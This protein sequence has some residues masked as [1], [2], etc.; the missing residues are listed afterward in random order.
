MK[1]LVPS[2]NK[3]EAK[4][5][6]NVWNYNGVAVPLDNVALTFATDFAN[7]VLKSFFVQAE[8]NM[9]KVIE[10]QVQLRLAAEKEKL[11]LEG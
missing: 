7:V 10:A 11:V 9:A 1:M 6:S 5:F 4:K 3:D 8:A 2:V